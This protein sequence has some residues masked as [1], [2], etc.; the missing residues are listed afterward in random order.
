MR[1]TRSRGRRTI[2]RAE[3]AV[4]VFAGGIDRECNAAV[5]TIAALVQKIQRAWHVARKQHLAFPEYGEFR[6]DQ[7]SEDPEGD[8]IAMSSLSSN[9][10]T[11]P[12]HS[13]QNRAPQASQGRR[14]DAIPSGAPRAA[15]RNGP[16]DSRSVSRSRTARRRP[17]AARQA[18]GATSSLRSASERIRKLGASA[19]HHGVDRAGFDQV[20]GKATGFHDGLSGVRPPIYE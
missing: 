3:I 12:G 19:R 20:S 7:F 17:K 4:V 9:P 18:F 15:R 1:L 16:S 6:H 11:R 2:P 8:A 14:P 5:E 10:R 13:R